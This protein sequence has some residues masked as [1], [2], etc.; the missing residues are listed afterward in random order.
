MKDFY[1]VPYPNPK[2]DYRDIEY[3]P[4]DL[5]TTGLN[6]K[7]DKIVSFG[8]GIIY[9]NRQDFKRCGHQLVHQDQALNEKSVVIHKIFDDH[10]ADAPPLEAALER[11]LPILAGRVMIAHH[12]RIEQ[13]FIDAACRR[14][15]GVPFEIPIVD[16]MV[17]E[18]RAL[19]RANKSIKGGS[20]RLDALRQKFNLPRY[21]AHNAMIDALAAGEL[22]LAQAEYKSGGRPMELRDLLL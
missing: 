14:I 12:A 9:D 22:F 13:T 4:L 11:I 16:T 15:Y 6:P 5:E 17:L 18:R 3:V 19:N 20:L 1:S 8:W 7:E 10:V 2:Q 21:R